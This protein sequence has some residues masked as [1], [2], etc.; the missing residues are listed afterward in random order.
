LPGRTRVTGPNVELTLYGLDAHAESAALDGVIDTGASV[1]CIDS[2]IAKRLGLIA[3]NRKLVQMA[4]GRLATSSIY[5]ARMTIQALGFDDLVQ[6]YAIEM[7]YP[8]GR[9]L[10]GR[11]FL[12]DYI[13]NYDGPRER[14]EFHETNRGA[15][16]YFP[17]TTSSAL[18]RSPAKTWR[19]Q[20]ASKLEPDPLR[21]R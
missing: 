10:L 5:T 4:D 8:S 18:G 7:D 21:Q 1:I 16:F 12:K 13:V 19:H 6:V 11:S 9:V 2:R 20:Q 17:T 3:S 15:E 14:F